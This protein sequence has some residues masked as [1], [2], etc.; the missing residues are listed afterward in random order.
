MSMGTRFDPSRFAFEELYATLADARSDEPVFWSDRYHAWVVT[1]YDDVVSVVRS[2]AFSVKGVLEAP[3]LGGYC[4]EARKVLAEGVDWMVTGHVQM[5]EGP[6][7]SRFRKALL[8]VVTPKRVQEMEPIVRRIIHDLID[9]MAARG[10]CE[11]CADFAY[12]LAMLTTL[13]M[14]GF[15]EAEKDMDKF[16]LWADDTFKLILKSMTPEEQ[17]AAAR[18]AVEFQHYIR[19]KIAARRASPRDD[20]LSNIVDL[21][22]NGEA[23]ITDD[24]MIIMFT[25]SFVG[26]GQET[27]KL[28]LT[29]L[30]LHV[31]N[32]P[33][34]WEAVKQNPEA[35]ENFVEEALRYDPPLLGLFRF[36]IRDTTVSGVEIKAGDKVFFLMGSANHDAEKYADSDRFCPFREKGASHLTF[37][38]GKH[39]CVGAGL[40]R[41]EMRL[42]LEILS[43]RL[44][45]LRLRP[46]QAITYNSTDASRFLSRL[47]LEWDV[48]A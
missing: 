13:R 5:D 2:D 25:H 24:E 3:Q 41:L 6:Q 46:G 39:F 1:R 36:C 9:K 38:T 37:N 8:S 29:N 21:L 34:Q 28:G 7:H 17:V 14:I 20:M 4:P 16:P 15:E 47:E 32:E 45:S 19:D 10:H 48:A 33:G 11:F 12:P 40:A 42:A 23:R 31:L 35:L 26:A 22:A 18:H 27:T 30:M 43:Q 44:P